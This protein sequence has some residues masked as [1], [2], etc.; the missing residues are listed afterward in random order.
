ML[1]LK[2]GR[3]AKSMSFVDPSTCMARARALLAIGEIVE[4][5]AL[6]R[7]TVAETLNFG[8]I[9][10]IRCHPTRN[11]RVA[12][13]FFFSQ[14]FFRSTFCNG[15]TAALEASLVGRDGSGVGSFG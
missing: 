9:A 8:N 10:R 12:L 6:L 13:H 15:A 3:H 1:F 5:L 7:G 11:S 4:G 2:I 14:C